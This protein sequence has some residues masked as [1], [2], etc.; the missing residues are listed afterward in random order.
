LWLSDL[1][2]RVHRLPPVQHKI[3]GD[4]GPALKHFDTRTVPPSEQAIRRARRR[5][6]HF[7]AVCTGLGG[8]VAMASVIHSNKVA[9]ASR[10]LGPDKLPRVMA[11]CANDVVVQIRRFAAEALVPTEFEA[12]LAERLHAD[13]PL[14]QPIPSSLYA[15]VAPC[16]D[17]PGAI[18]LHPSSRRNHGHSL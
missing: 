16:S 17:G 5:R 4:H 9:I 6:A 15:P 10:Y 12:G 3:P 8:R 11:R 2:H 18:D 7:E 13:A 1:N 14:G